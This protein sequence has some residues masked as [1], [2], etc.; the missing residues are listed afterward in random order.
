MLE[1]G[2]LTNVVSERYVGWETD[3]GRAILAGERSLADI[4]DAALASGLNP[5]PRSGRQEYLESLRL[6]T[7]LRRRGASGQR[8]EGRKP[9]IA[10]TQPP[11]RA[12]GISSGEDRAQPG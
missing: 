6:R 12:A 5:Q 10:H 3:A 11:E 9:R 2:T 7:C 1:A 8:A 4:A